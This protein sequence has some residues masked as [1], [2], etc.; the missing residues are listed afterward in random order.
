MKYVWVALLV[1]VLGG[2]RGA[3]PQPP[4]TPRV[5][6]PTDL[7]GYWV[8]IVS[9]DWRWRMGLGLKG[10]YGYLTLFDTAEECLNYM[11]EVVANDLFSEAPHAIYDLASYERHWV[12]VEVRLPNYSPILN[13]KANL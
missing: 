5:A 2:Q 10:D 12:S 8:S 6:A 4:P 13:R 1:G 9:E 11:N 7:V 3:P